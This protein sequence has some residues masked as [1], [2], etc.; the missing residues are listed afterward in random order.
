MAPAQISIQGHQR[1]C[2]YYLPFADTNLRGQLQEH[3]SRKMS[4]INYANFTRIVHSLNLLN[5]WSELE[6]TGIRS[7]RDTRHY[8][9]S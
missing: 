6:K 7:I 9:F 1:V 2:M 4:E 3:W 5:V 8:E